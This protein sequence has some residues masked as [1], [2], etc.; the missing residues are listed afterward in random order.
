MNSL[1]EQIISAETKV[2]KKPDQKQKK[3]SSKNVPSPRSV[4]QI[5][6]VLNDHGGDA[7]KTLSVQRE[8]A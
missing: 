3:K 7:T 8:N 1:K 2:L 6:A 4:N 5:N